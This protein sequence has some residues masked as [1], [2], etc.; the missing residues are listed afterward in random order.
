[1]SR[2]LAGWQAVVYYGT[3]GS[4]AATLISA[5]VVDVD[6]GQ[7]FEYVDQPTRGDGTT[8]P[9]TDEQP[10]LRKAAPKFSM[11]YHDTDTH[12]VALL[13]AAKAEPPV[14]K[15]FKILRKLSGEVEF[16]GDAFIKYSSAGPLKEGQLVEFELHP[17]SA[18][19]R[20]WSPD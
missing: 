3:A 12:M 4:A 15:A 13:A 14:G 8:L 7:D 16:D 9:Q 1:M 2:K 17:T 6:A 19:G 18:Y 11:E 10:V 5:N 20:N